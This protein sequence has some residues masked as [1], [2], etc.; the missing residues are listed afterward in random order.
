[1]TNKYDGS[2]RRLDFGHFVDRIFWTLI[3]A[4]ALY[5]AHSINELNEKVAV[6]I[7]HMSGT[8]RRLGVLEDKLLGTKGRS[9]RE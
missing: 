9:Q 3:T 6:V 2:E 4:A 8:D 1:M 7:E 5:T